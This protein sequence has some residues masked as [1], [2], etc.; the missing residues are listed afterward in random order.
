MEILGRKAEKALLKRCLE[1]AKPE[2]LA[3]YGRR[4]VGKTY[5]IREYCKDGI[6]FSMT[7]AANS[8]TTKQLDIFNE[9]LAEYG[10]EGEKPAKNWFEAFKLLKQ[11]INTSVHKGKKVVFIDELPWFAT[12]KSGFVSALEH[13]WNQWG[14]AMPDLLLIVCGS[15][16]S[17][18]I[19]NVIKNHG[20]LHNRVTRRLLLEPFTLGECEAFLASR[21]IVFTRYQIAETYM[22]FGGIPYYLDYLDEGLSPAQN[23]DNLCFAKSGSLKD[24]FSELYA[25][26]FR[27]PK[28]HISVIEALSLHSAGMTRDEIATAIA[29]K[30]GGTLTRI[31]EELEQC[32][33]IE[34]RRDFTRKKNGHYYYLTDFFTI[35]Y[36]KHMRNTVTND[37]LYWQHHANKGGQL[38]WHGLA[39]ERLCMAH[40]P[41][42]KQRLGISGV[43]T[44]IT[45]WRSK[46]SHPGA[47]I[48]L[49]IDR[50]DGIINVCEI[51]FARKPFSI[52]KEFDADLR[53]RRE[54][55]RE[56]SR[57]TKALHTT[58]ITA[59]GITAEAYRGEIQQEVTLD[60][61]F[62]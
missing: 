48:D 2:F 44:D 25:S 8:S 6:I 1:S 35:F 4:R 36:L 41:Q 18:I 37:P 38:A 56:E 60:D 34:K 40:V 16:T 22:T 19:N 47:Q 43:S 58:M 32:G 15:A 28:K 27:S 31:L 14:S 57:T 54:T 50:E 20:G 30:T 51:K 9:A 7:G 45:S 61:L 21:N 42:I 33:F 23:I 55:F 29:N 39:F 53:Y 62:V 46:L 10:S 26:L 17:W 11:L 13:F 3:V 12:A 5:L 59:F 24:E 52:T 49:L